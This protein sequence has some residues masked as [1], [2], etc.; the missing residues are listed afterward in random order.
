MEKPRKPHKL[1]DTLIKE[2]PARNDAHVAKKI[3]WS[4]KFVSTLR[5]GQAG[6]SPHRILQL[7]D[8]TGWEISRIKELL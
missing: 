2:L 4:Q 7:H 1:L 5:S 3:G 8:K 6:M